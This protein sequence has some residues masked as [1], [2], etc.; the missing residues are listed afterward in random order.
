VTK[1]K[2][3]DSEIVARVSFKEMYSPSLIFCFFHRIVWNYQEV[4]LVD[5]FDDKNDYFFVH[6]FLSKSSI[7]DCIKGFF[8][9]T[10]SMHIVKRFTY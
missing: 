2:F 7:E 3:K 10:Y 4:L 1:N 5:A 9:S 8:F 6:G